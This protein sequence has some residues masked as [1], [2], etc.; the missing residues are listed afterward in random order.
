MLQ[1]LNSVFKWWFKSNR[2]L[3]WQQ[4]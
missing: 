1:P 2:D 4:S 3:D